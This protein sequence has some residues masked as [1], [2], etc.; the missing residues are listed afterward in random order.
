MKAAIRSKFTEEEWKARFRHIKRL[1]GHYSDADGSSGHVQ[2]ESDSVS[3]FK[4]KP[5]KESFDEDESEQQDVTDLSINEFAA[6]SQIANKAIL[7]RTAL[8]RNYDPQSSNDQ[9]SY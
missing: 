9:M 1:D 6:I 2:D 8:K 3:M 7:N 4:V 5:R